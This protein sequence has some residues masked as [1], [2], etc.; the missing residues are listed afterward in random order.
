MPYCKLKSVHTTVQ[1]TLNYILNPEKTDELL[2]ADSINCFT[3]AP[4]A[5]DNMKM[6]YEH[7]S[8]R[9]FTAPMP[10]NG[11]CPI[12]AIHL[13]QSFSP[14]DGVT[15]EQVHEIGMELVRELY[16][17][18]VQAVVTTHVDKEHI[19]NH[20]LVCSYTTDGRKLYNTISEVKRLRDLS[21]FLCEV[22]GIRNV[23]EERQGK[24]YSIS[25]SEWQ[26]RKR[27]TSWKAHISAYIDSL[28]PVAKNLEHLLQIMEAHGY[29][30]KRG[31]YISVRAP[32]QKRAIRLKTLGADYAEDALAERIQEYLDA[33]PKPRTLNEIFELI[34]REFTRE[35]RNICFAAGVKDT[36]ELLCKQLALINN[37]HISSVGEAEQLLENAQKRITELETAITD[38]SAEARHKQ[39]VAAAA[40]RY[41]GKHKFREYPNA[42]RKSDKLILARAGITAITDV[43]GYA[44]DVAAD[45]ERLAEM[46]AELEEQKKR[47]AVLRGIIR[48]YGDGDDY[49]TK[50]VKRTREKLDEQEQARVRELQAKMYTVYTPNDPRNFHISRANIDYYKQSFERSLF[51]VSANPDDVVETLTTIRDTDNLYE[52][53]VICLDNIGYYLDYN[54]I[55]RVD[56]FVQ[57]RVEIERQRQEEL[58]R[59]EKER[60]EAEERRRQKEEQERKK[61]EEKQNQPSAPKKKKKSI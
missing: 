49:I 38:L 27:G 39:I 28:I 54:K 50:L 3:D 5:Y 59:Q 20:V 26:H 19:H 57:S 53:D 1:N 21:D 34:Q 41:F 22:R 13:I 61:A 46:Q 44:D 16:G 14:E 60:I 12:K 2:Y 11:N 36:T 37:E 24:S 6:I 35:T 43:S 51:D 25:Y 10:K 42:Q 47:E 58:A 52:G 45:N 32:D 7:Y 17:D 31:M 18:K 48:T 9:S 29:T 30:V 55:Y 33:Q 15:P 8:G 40:E 4:C 56:D 23:M